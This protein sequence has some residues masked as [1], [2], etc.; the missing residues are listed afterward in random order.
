LEQLSGKISDMGRIARMQLD[1]AL[2]A[3]INNDTES[4]KSIVARDSVVD[5]LEHSI[6]RLTVHLLA[7]R[8]PVAVDLRTIISALRIATDME[9]IADYV[10]NIARQ[11]MTL[12]GMG[13]DNE[14]RESVIGMAEI[15][16]D[17]LGN[18]LEAYVKSD[19]QKALDVRGHDLEIDKLYA[20]LLIRL[21]VCMMSDPGMVKTC[22]ALLF[23]ARCLERIGDHIKNVAEDIYFIVTGEILNGDQ[24]NNGDHSGEKN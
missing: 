14:L 21:R 22:T 4:A 10:V 1:S 5:A 24:S 9:R 23:V 20:T 6:H 13:I 15:A 16:R 17:M 11:V 3:F 18:I 12:N 2:E 19:I 8:Q 7:L